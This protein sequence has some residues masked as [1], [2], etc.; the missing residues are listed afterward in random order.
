M[1]QD[2]GC[3]TT[4]LGGIGAT[5]APASRPRGIQAA[6]SHTRV[7]GKSMV[8]YAEAVSQSRGHGGEEVGQ[9]GWEKRRRAKFAFESD[10]NHLPAVTSPRKLFQ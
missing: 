10:C 1:L 8:N 2:G 6:A 3:G 5:P 4:P 9:L 7:A